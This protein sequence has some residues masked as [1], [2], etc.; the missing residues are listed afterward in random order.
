MNAVDDELAQLLDKA[1]ERL[2]TFRRT[3][4]EEVALGEVWENG[5]DISPQ[6]DP[7]GRFALAYEADG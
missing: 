7:Q 3:F 6:A 5:F 4:I 1:V 2:S